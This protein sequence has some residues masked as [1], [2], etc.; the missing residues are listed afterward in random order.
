[1]HIY[2]IPGTSRRVIWVRDGATNTFG[3]SAKVEY[4]MEVGGAH[5]RYVC[6]CVL[7]SVNAANSTSITYMQPRMHV[8][9]AELLSHLEH[10]H[11]ESNSL[12][13]LIHCEEYCHPCMLCPRNAIM[14]IS[15]FPFYKKKNL[16]LHRHCLHTVQT[17]STH[18]H[19]ASKAIHQDAAA[20]PRRTYHT[21]S[22]TLYK[23]KIYIH[24]PVYS[25]KEPPFTHTTTPRVTWKIDKATFSGYT[26]K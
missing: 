1:M 24:L 15:S 18:I 26:V 20:P 23:W 22:V 6:L 16:R 17:R 3:T 10:E 11:Q 8:T 14:K 7:V 19:I 9:S 5:E 13:V 12:C 4:W 21:H 25:N 2:N